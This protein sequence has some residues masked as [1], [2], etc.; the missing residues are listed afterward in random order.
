MTIKNKIILVTGGAGFIGSHL[1][2]ELS[3]KNEVTV[4]DNY[5]TGSKTNHIKGVN[6]IE[7]DTKDIF[8]LIKFKPD[9][10]FHLGEYSRVEESFRDFDKVLDSNLKGTQ[11]VLQ[12]CLEFG[13]KLIYAGSSTKFADKGSDQSPYAWSKSSNTELVKNC[14]DWF[15][16]DYVITYFYNAFGP[17]EIASGRHATLIGIY[18]ENMC[19]GEPLKVVL[20]GTQV[21]NFTYV[22]D[23]VSGICLA[24]EFGAGDGYGIGNSKSYSV[25]DVAQMFGGIVET[26]PERPGNRMSGPL[27]TEKILELG[28]SPKTELTDYI[29]ELQ[30]KNWKH[31]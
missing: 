28:W 18:M 5:S 6:Y 19:K 3:K 27:V 13:C 26:I 11:C 30:K 12:L 2:E 9:V 17:L 10:V 25:N 16:L 24:A 8:S 22:K 7:G 21:R 23:I 29:N 1:C 15:G 14:G 20:P 31:N 4:L